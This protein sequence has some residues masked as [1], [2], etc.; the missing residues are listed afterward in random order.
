MLTRRAL[1]PFLAAAPFQRRAASQ[2][3]SSAEGVPSPK[4]TRL[5][6][7]GDVMLSRYVGR[8]SRTRRDPASPLR[9]LAPFLRSADIALVNLESP[10][11]DHGRSLDEG[12][13]FHAE[14]EMI[15]G[16]ELAGIDVVS[17]ANNHARDCGRHGVEFTVGWLEKHGLRWRDRACPR[18]RLTLARLS[19][20]TV[21]ASDFSVIPSI[22]RM[23]I[24]K[25]RTIAWH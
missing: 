25:T 8:L 12:M 21:C 6:F 7:G 14:P 2:C 24:I 13:V 4:R 1:L 3:P 19:C 11:S 10:F 23:E 18:R 20:A 9:E 15:A 5:I 16:L 22:N 17:T